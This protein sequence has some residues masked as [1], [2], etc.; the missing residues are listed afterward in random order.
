MVGPLPRS[1]PTNGLATHWTAS[2][3]VESFGSK[4]TS[5]WIAIVEPAVMAAA[6]S[7]S[8]RPSPTEAHSGW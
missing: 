5:L 3:R 8:G 2:A 1:S 6:L 7:P 4:S